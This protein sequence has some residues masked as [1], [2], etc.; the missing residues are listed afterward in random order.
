MCR[1]CGRK[2][3]DLVVEPI[4]PTAVSDDDYITLCNSCNWD[5]TQNNE[6]N[7]RLILSPLTKRNKVV[8]VGDCHSNFE[9]LDKV[10]SSEE[11]FDFFLSVGDVGSLSKVSPSDLSIIERW[12][13]KGFFVRGNHDDVEF[14]NQ[15]GL[16]QEIGGLTVSGLSGMLKSRTFLKDKTNNISFRDVLYLSR[17]KK[18]DILVTHQPPTGLFNNVGESVLEDVL[19]FVVPQIYICGHIHRYKLKF[20]LT[21]F[22]ISLPMIHKGYAVAHFQGKDLRNLEVIFRKGKKVIRI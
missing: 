15:L 16:N 11:P 2:W 21:T 4:T 14:F 10:L 6:E 20:H 8:L 3:I 1:V 17:L 12:R 18:V 5:M 22:I 13:S 7:R 19:D 9:Q